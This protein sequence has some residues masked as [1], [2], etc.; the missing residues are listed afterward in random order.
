MHL[1]ALTAPPPDPPELPEGV[2][3]RPRWP[4]WYG[5]VGFVAAIVATLLASV[6]VLLGVGAVVEIAGG[7]FDA[8]GEEVTV[9]GTILQD[10]ALILTAVVFARMTLR[11]RPWHFGL[12]PARF[13]PALAWTV[14]AWVTFIVLAI[15]YTAA[16]QPDGEQTVAEDLGADES[17]L[18]LVIGALMVII[19]APVAEEFFF[20][21]FFYGALRSTFNV[22]LAA[23]IN[24]AVF[25]AIHIT[26]SETLPL[27]P[28]LAILGVILCL[29]Y[30][31]TGSL[32]API[33]L[34]AFNNTIAYTAATEG[35][36][37]LSLVIPVSLGLG[38]AMLAACVLVPR[39]VT[40]EAPAAA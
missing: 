15:V 21:G 10:A 20:R 11:P 33:A 37:D 34:H 17:A 40:R 36:A 2:E 13:G 9:I 38:A 3:V 39:Y 7:D 1:P 22:P 5:P 16:V 12:R 14:G 6:V 18:G 25:G 23:L 27:V 28:V 26:S 4:W 29:L 30:E 35:S 19:V 32:Y 8:D 31:R 24:G